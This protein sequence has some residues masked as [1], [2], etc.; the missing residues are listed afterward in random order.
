MSAATQSHL[1]YAQFPAKIRVG[2]SGAQ[3]SKRPSAGRSKCI[4][5]AKPT[6]RLKQNLRDVHGDRR[7]ITYGCCR[8]TGVI[9]KGFDVVLN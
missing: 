1:Q 2:G 6:R 5:T 3:I 7:N 9:S 4:D 8:K